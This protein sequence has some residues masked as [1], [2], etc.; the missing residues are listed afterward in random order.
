M[1]YMFSLPK[2]E[3]VCEQC[4]HLHDSRQCPIRGKGYASRRV[5]HLGYCCFFRGWVQISAHTVTI[6]QEMF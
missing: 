4:E 5:L 1:K 3:T 6:K 2:F